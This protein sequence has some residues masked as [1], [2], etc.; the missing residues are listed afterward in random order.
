VA[1]NDLVVLDHLVLL[2]GGE[3][4]FVP[5]RVVANGSG[6]GLGLTRCRLPGVTAEEFAEDAALVA[7]DLQALKR[8][9]EQ[10]KGAW[11]RERRL[12]ARATALRPGAARRAA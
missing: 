3:V 1:R 10:E 12:A 4:V 7:R 9:L 11:G 2:R 8:R 6:G 5:M